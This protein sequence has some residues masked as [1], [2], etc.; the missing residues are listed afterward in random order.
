MRNNNENSRS[1]ELANCNTIKTVLMILIVLYH[2]MIMYASSNWFRAPVH[3]SP[4]IGDIAQW[5][6]SFHIYSFT[7]ISGYIFYYVKFE[8][9]GYETY[10]KLISNK[11][12]RLVLPYMVFVALWAIPVYLL[13]FEADGKTIIKKFVLADEP[14][15]FWFL[16]M[17]FWVFAIFGIIA[18]HVDMHP[19]IGIGGLC[20]LY[21]FG[22]VWDFTLDFFQLFNGF[23]YA[24]FF[25]AGFLMRKFGFTTLKKI[26]GPI[27]VVVDILLYILYSYS[28]QLPVNIYTK[29]LWLGFQFVLNMF[30]SIA[31][32]VA[33]Q[34]LTEHFLKESK[35]IKCL[36]KHSMSVYL[37]HQQLIYFTIDWFNGIVPPV[38]LV[39]INFAFSLTVS[40]LFSVLMHKTKVTRFLVGSK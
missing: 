3:P 38:V 13:F 23:R 40:T 12:L 19:F 2:S 22:T 6:N 9:G 4:I 25:G 33:L 1:R 39:L 24:I 8:R 30:G 15:Q 10:K 28:L 14:E 7:L 36:S 26:P 21:L 31:A 18:K 20:V 35:F 27:Y 32:F 11:L 17:L 37:V 16:L 5:M 34:W 29:I